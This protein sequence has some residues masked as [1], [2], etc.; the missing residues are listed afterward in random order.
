[1]IIP[2][3]F[4][5]L[6]KIP[7]KAIL[8]FGNFSLIVFIADDASTITWLESFLCLDMSFVP[9]CVTIRFTFLF[10][11]LVTALLSKVKR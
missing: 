8:A 10:F 6:C 9:R 1:M 2:G 11:Y 3:D 7:E 4:P 5:R